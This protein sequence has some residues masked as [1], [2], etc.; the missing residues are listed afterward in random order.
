MT[1]L[2]SISTGPQFITASV[3]RS[4][5][6]YGTASFTFQSNVLLRVQG[7]LPVPPPVCPGLTTSATGPPA[8]SGRR[9]LA[10]RDI[11]HIWRRISQTSI[12]LSRR[13]FPSS[14]R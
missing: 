12:S 14:S 3:R 10:G 7:T 13:V 9:G 2:A 1:A 6:L 4:A 8:P 5:T 11:V